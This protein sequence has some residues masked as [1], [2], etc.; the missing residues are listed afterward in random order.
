MT[1]SFGEA[2]LQSLKNA[3]RPG[4]E[5][6]QKQQTTFYSSCWKQVLEKMKGK[7]LAGRT[8]KPLFP[9]FESRKLRGS[10]KVCADTYVTADSG[11][12]L[13][14]QAP[15]F[16]EDDYRVSLANGEGTALQC[17]PMLLRDEHFHA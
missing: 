6:R 1:V 5:G 12:G 16:G 13:V 3:Q 7:E 9:Y 10:F 8:Y 11:T 4:R 14:H 15:A 2:N 17:L